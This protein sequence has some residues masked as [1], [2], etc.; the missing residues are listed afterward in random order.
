MPVR[1]KVTSKGQITLPKQVRDELGLAPGDSVSFED[2]DDGTLVI[3][4]AVT[5]PK[6]LAGLIEY[7]GPALTNQDIVDLV[8]ASRRGEGAQLLAR[9]KEN[10]RDR[11]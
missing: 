4:K 9:L 8:Q 6:S 5:T 2:K 10:K 3:S 1:A 11:A 7:D